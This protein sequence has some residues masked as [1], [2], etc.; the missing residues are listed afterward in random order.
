[1]SR[2]P[3]GLHR[4]VRSTVALSLAAGVLGLAG[5]AAAITHTFTFRDTLLPREGGAA[6]VPVYNGAGSATILTQGMTGFVNGSYVTQTITARACA[7]QPTVRAWSFPAQGGLRHPNMAP[8]IASGS[9][10][11][12]MLVRF[13]PQTGGYARLVD[14]SNSTL[15]TGIYELGGGVSFYPVG[16]YAAGSF[17]QAEDTFVTLTRDATTRVVNLYI[18]GV[19][20]GTYTDST[21]L[22]APASG[23]LY[24]FMDNTTGSAAISESNAGVVSYLQ[25]ADA[26]ITPTAVVASLGE[27]C[28]AVRCGNG[29]LE[30]GEGCDS[31]AG[32]GS[33]TCDSMCRIRSGNPCNAAAPGATGNASCASMNCLTTGVPAPG[34]CAQCTS[35]AQCSGDTPV[36]NAATNLCVACNASGAGACNAGL[37][38]D[39]SSGRCVTMLDA[40][41]VDSGTDTGP[42]DTGPADTGPADTGPADTG[43]RD[44]GVGDGSVTIDAGGLDAGVADA[45]VRDVGVD[46]GAMADAGVEV[47]SGKVDSGKVDA[48]EVDAGLMDV[49]DEGS[50]GCRTTRPSSSGP[51]LASALAALTWLTIARRRRNGAT[52]T[53]R[54]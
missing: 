5:P 44:V 4:R 52:G 23:T 27:I 30:A 31:G 22:Y 24:F 43:A 11:L 38:C 1:M 10:T 50:C 51:A 16:T 41:A 37:V 7:S 15:D 13:N 39:P 34:R 29:V 47:D 46:S 33:T 20:S 14:F 36:C 19:A 28:V 2:R 3:K 35:N 40:G 26:P 6:L 48:G 9:Y 17:V 49:T 21:D 18:N 8:V 53:E 54:R 42:A 32:N 25:I 45:G 12:S